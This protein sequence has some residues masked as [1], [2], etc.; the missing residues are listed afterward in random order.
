M[1]IPDTSSVQ[2][3]QQ[4][5]HD[6]NELVEELE[7]LIWPSLERLKSALAPSR[8]DDILKECRSV[9]LLSSTN[10]FMLRSVL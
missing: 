8:L 10:K 9:W 5:Q 1:T 7:E 2:A 4:L 6:D 3:S